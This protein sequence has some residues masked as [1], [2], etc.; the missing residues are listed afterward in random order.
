[1]D[2]NQKCYRA[3]RTGERRRSSIRGCIVGHDIAVL[4]LS[5]SKKG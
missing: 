3:R 5:I 1:L 2:K 4:S